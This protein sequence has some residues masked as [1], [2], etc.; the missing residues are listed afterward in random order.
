MLTELRSA[1][2]CAT[3]SR[4]IALAV[5]RSAAIDMRASA[6]AISRIVAD[7]HLE[8]VFAF[9]LGQGGLALLDGSALD[10]ALPDADAASSGRD[11]W[12]DAGDSRDRYEAWRDAMKTQQ[13]RHWASAAL[14]D[15]GHSIGVLG[16]GSAVPWRADAGRRVL[17]H[18]AAVSCGEA[19]A[20]AAAHEAEVE[21]LRAAEESTQRLSAL[22]QERIRAIEERERADEMQ[23]HVAAVVGHDLRNPL[24]AL[25]YAVKLLEG[26]RPRLT[27]GER[28]YLDRIGST[29]RRME[30]LIRD[31]LDHAR[32]QSGQGLPLARR[33]VDVRRL[34]GEVIEELEQ[35]NPGRTV[36][37]E[38][39][40][41]VH[42]NCDPERMVQTIGN[43][44]ANALKHGASEPPVRVRCRSDETGVTI[45]VENAGPAMSDEVSHRLF[46][47]FAQGDRS[48]NGV[49]L[50][51]F[52]ARQIARAHGG[53]IVAHSAPG[54]T[55]FTVFV[56]HATRAAGVV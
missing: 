43:L 30:R 19:L 10:A 28:R 51:L 29:A 37:L 4:Q 18:A 5:L 36:V 55:V 41:E 2:G 50:G 16:L 27:P 47:P 46:E 8:V 22:A 31:L 26:A 7:D 32:L 3:T 34:C 25:I 12:L 11:V 56:P 45:E 21:R 1:L 13:V 20:R 42:G 35:A 38:H 48:G 14:L 9:G 54:K 33:D 39:C 23:R 53:D 24:G 15:R 52:I 6:G 17:V 40:G 44:V 49:G